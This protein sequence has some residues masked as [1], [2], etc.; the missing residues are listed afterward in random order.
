M[1]PTGGKQTGRN[2]FNKIN[3]LQFSAAPS[4][5][6]TTDG[7]KEQVQTWKKVHLTLLLL[8]HSLTDHAYKNEKDFLEC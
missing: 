1:K 4:I 2:E 8:F 3:I 7:I 5:Q 6:K